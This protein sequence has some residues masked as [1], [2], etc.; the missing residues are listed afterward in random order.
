MNDLKKCIDPVFGEMEY[1]HGWFKNSVINLFGK[2]WNIKL[3]AQAYSEKNINN[4]QRENYSWFK[5]NFT[6]L[7]DK[8]F[9]L[10]KNYINN[11]GGEVLLIEGDLKEPSFSD[12]I[13]KRTCE[14]FGKPDILVNNAGV[15]I[16]Q[17]SLLDI[18]DE[19][20]DYT[21]ERWFDYQCKF[22]YYFCWRA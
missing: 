20:F 14:V 18:S 3:T 2:N 15:Q 16:E 8:I 22:S 21:N 7:Q 12:F 1:K 6:N 17:E 13:V 9:N 5:Q 4:I 19:Q 11:F 10:T